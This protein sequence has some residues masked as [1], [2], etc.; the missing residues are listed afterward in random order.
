MLNFPKRRRKQ[1]EIPL[2]SLIDIVFLL[3]IYFLLTS[4]FVTQQTLDIQL[5]QGEIDTPAVEQLVVIGLDK[6]GNFYF[7]DTLA[8]ERDL[9]YLLQVA[10]ARALRP[11]VVIKADREARYDRVVRAM[12]IAKTSGASRLHLAIDRK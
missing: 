9:A 4:N 5:P 1:V 11:E 8:G 10:L 3:L 2:T 6:Q 12:E 7:G